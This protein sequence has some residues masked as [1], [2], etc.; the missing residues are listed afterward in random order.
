MQY[1]RGIEA[2][3]NTSPTAMTLG[4]FDGLHLG[5]D[6]LIQRVM[7]HQRTD[8]VDSVVF[9]FDMT[10]LY[11]Q[12][13]KETAGL[14]TN[15]ERA[16]RLEGKVDY[17][18]ECPFV[19]SISRIE[20]EVFVKEIL[21]DRFHVKYVVV[22]DDFHFGYQKRGDWQMLKRLGELY[23]F[24]V[25]VVP[26][27]CHNGREISSTYIKELL[28]EGK[29]DLVN[30]LLGYPYCLEGEVI[31]GKQLG[32]TI[33][34]PTMNLKPDPQKRIPPYGVYVCKVKL[35]QKEYKGICNIGVKPTVSEE[36][37]I[38]LETHI[39][40]YQGDA[41]GKWVQIF[42]YDFERPE[43]RFASLEEL[44]KTIKKDR[45]YAEKYFDSRNKL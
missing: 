22:G 1:V 4:K 16:L 43:C 8:R 15:Q 38:L 29:M 20:A 19:D 12:L 10:P 30:R 21:V 18:V 11:R 39:L 23:G 31:H 13:G 27:K 5:H 41:Y 14:I 42:L 33:G 2:Y 37:E 24:T 34:F 35:D 9:A 7:E 6:I 45:E 3:Q 26:K 40:E 32:R 17:L 25:E 36:E 28:A 44:Q